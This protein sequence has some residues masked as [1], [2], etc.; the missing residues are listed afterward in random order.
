[1]FLKCPRTQ[2]TIMCRHRNSA[3]LCPG[4]KSHCTVTPSSSPPT[5]EVTSS[6]HK[7]RQ[8][9]P[10]VRSSYSQRRTDVLYRRYA[11]PNFCAKYLSSLA[12]TPYEIRTSVGINIARSHALLTQIPMPM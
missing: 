12:M 6:I 8:L 11:S 1:M 9:Q 3:A 5:A 4:S 2:V 7:R 10:L